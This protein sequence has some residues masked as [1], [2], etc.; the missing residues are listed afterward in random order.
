M[1]GWSKLLAPSRIVFFWWFMV[2]VAGWWRT[3]LA[4]QRRRVSVLSTDAAAATLFVCLPLIS[5]AHS[6]RGLARSQTSQP[7]KKNHTKPQ[8]GIEVGATRARSLSV[9]LTPPAVKGAASW[10]LEFRPRRRTVNY[11]L[12]GTPPP[13]YPQTGCPPLSNTHPTASAPTT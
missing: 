5:L 6:N 7:T 8:A 11:H 2:I 12:S 1:A 13:G 9:H 3:D 4:L 10:Q